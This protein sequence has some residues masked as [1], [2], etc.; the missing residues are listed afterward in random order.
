MLA[1]HVPEIMFIWIS[2]KNNPSEFIEELIDDNPEN[3]E[4]I[5]YN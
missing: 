1:L 3:L 2:D 5:E 4:I